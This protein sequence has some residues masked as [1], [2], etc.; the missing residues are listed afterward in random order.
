[1]E[2]IASF[3]ILIGPNVFVGAEIILWVKKDAESP[4]VVI[5]LIKLAVLAV[6]FVVQKRHPDRLM[7]V[8]FPF[9]LQTHLK[10]L[11]GHTAR[12]TKN[13]KVVTKVAPSRRAHDEGK[14][15]GVELQPRVT[16]DPG[17]I[18]IQ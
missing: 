10:S 4:V 11:I 8:F 18:R 14:E 1:M 5:H 12:L 3:L 6:S 16:E 13:L 7:T 17:I 15:T 9:P 2:T